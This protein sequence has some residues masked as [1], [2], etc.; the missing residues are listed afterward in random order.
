MSND[1]TQ[2]V[3]LPLRGRLRF[4]FSDC[5]L[6]GGAAAISRFTSLLTFPLLTRWYSVEEYG[7]LDAV[8][9]LTNLLTL[10][11]V[12]GQDSALARYFYEYEDTPVRRQVASQS[13]A[14]QLFFL[15]VMLPGL[16]VFAE[17]LAHVYTNRSG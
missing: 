11:L 6:Y 16:W 10:L 5:M 17:Q 2:L 7:L 1:V 3:N 4:L 8:I 14:I 13:L 12:F 9:V 15:A